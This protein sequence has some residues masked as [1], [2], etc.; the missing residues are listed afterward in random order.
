MFE[1]KQT[2][3]LGSCKDK[4]WWLPFDKLIAELLYPTA[5]YIHESNK[6]TCDLEGVVAATKCGIQGYQESTSV[7]LSGIG[8][9][10]IAANV[11]EDNRKATMMMNASTSISESVHASSTDEL[12]TCGT[13]WLDSVTTEA[14]T[15]A[16]N[17]CGRGLSLW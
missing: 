7:S 15:R 16:N 1:E 6:I 4:D 9:V 10:R 17:D 12:V 8:G 5:Y 13:I 11:S 2:F 3:A 14:Q